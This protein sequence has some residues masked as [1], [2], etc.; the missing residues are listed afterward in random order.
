[1]HPTPR[2]VLCMSIA[3]IAASPI[4]AQQVGLVPVPVFQNVQ[5]Q[6]QTTFDLGPGFY[7]F[8]YTINNPATNTGQIVSIHIDI[9]GGGAPFGSS[10]LTI[11]IGGRSLFFDNFVSI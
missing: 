5:V 4:Q 11:P 7:T 10:G 1:M 6:A 9:T 2:L 3:C 8:A